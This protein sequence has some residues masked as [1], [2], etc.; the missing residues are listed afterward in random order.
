MLTA[1]AHLGRTAHRQTP[2]AHVWAWGTSRMMNAAPRAHDCVHHPIRL[3]SALCLTRMGTRYIHWAGAKLTVDV[4]LTSES[5]PVA[6]VVISPPYESHTLIVPSLEPLI[7]L[8]PSAVKATHRIRPWC[9]RS[10]TSSRMRVPDANGAVHSVAQY[11]SPVLVLDACPLS[12][13]ALRARVVSPLPAMHTVAVVC[14]TVIV[15]HD[16]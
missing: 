16:H 8:R 4:H 5:H 13:G 7:T 10:I 15:R 1:Q 11:P 6:N 2:H 3:S 9:S 14:C 12:S